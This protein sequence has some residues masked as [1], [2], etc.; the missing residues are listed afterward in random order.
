MAKMSLGLDIGHRE[1]KGVQLQ[2]RGRSP[3]LHSH[4][5]TATPDRAIVKGKVAQTD[6]LSAALKQLVQDNGWGGSWT[7]LGLTHPELVV[8]VVKFP[9]MRERELQEVISFELDQMVSFSFSS[10][11]D[12]AYSYEVLRKVDDEQEVLF[13][14][15][16]MDLMMP[17]VKAARAAGLEVAVVDVQGLA[18]PKILQESNHYA[19]INIGHSQ[20]HIYVEI[21]GMY[22]ISRLLSIG[23]DHFTEGIMD[24]YNLSY[25]AADSR[26]R[27]YDVDNLLTHAT[28][29]VSSLRSSIQQLVGGALQ[30]LDY[31][32]AQERVTSIGE[33][34]DCIY[35]C[36]GSAQWKGLPEL[37]QEELE[38]KVE[39]VDPFALCPNGTEASDG[40]VSYAVAASLACRGLERE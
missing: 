14:A 38:L 1:I 34:L 35:L 22:R 32:R 3:R 18:L 33:V 17:Y 20:T 36:G 29:S 40:N 39:V 11:E 9:L 26:K 30:T 7:V 4:A 28:G 12:V 23:G 25:S 16:H 21:D 13:A 27:S 6:N 15:C 8:K 37:L 10:P 24:A 19:F 31:V 5:S 2:G